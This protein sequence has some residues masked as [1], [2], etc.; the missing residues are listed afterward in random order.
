MRSLPLAGACVEWSGLARWHAIA[1]LLSRRELSIFEGAEGF[2]KR[3]RCNELTGGKGAEMFCAG[4]PQYCVTTVTERD[5]ALGETPIVIKVR[6]PV[7]RFPLSR[8]A[9]GSSGKGKPRL[10]SFYRDRQ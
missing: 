4:F 8:V 2:V 1:S 9:R 5:L 3:C 7:R 6:E 10:A